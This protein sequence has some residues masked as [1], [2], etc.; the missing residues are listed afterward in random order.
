[1][2]RTGGGVGCGI[3]MQESVRA[4][5]VVTMRLQ[6]AAGSDDLQATSH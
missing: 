4:R 6:R 1:V 5:S 2:T 3:G